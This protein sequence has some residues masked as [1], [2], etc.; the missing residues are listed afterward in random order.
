MTSSIIAVNTVP[1]NSQ[2]LPQKL[3]SP[4]PVTQFLPTDTTLIGIVN[5]KTEKWQSLTKFELFA[6]IFN[7]VEKQL[8]TQMGLNYQTDIKPWLGEQVAFT[9]LPQKDIKPGSLEG[10]FLLL[11]TV[12]DEQSL[13]VLIDRLKSSNAQEVTE[14]QYKGVKILEWKPSAPIAPVS[15]LPKSSVAAVPGI[16][17]LPMPNRN[18]IKNRGMAI[19][20]LPGYIVTASTAKPIE[21]L[22]DKP[23]GSANLAQNPNFKQLT[24]HPQ[25][26]QALFT[27]YED[28]TKVLSLFKSLAQ[29]PSLPFPIAPSAITSAQVEQY[30]SIDGLVWEQPEGLRLQLFAHRKTPSLANILTPNTAQL[31]PRIPAPAYSATT[32]SNIYLQWQMLETALNGYPQFKDGLAKLNQT[33]TSTTGLDLN[34]DILGWMDGEYALFSYPTEQGLISSQLKMGLGFFVQTTN[35]S[36]AESTLNKLGQSLKTLSGGALSTNTYNDIDGFNVNSWNFGEQSIFAYSWVDDK[37]LLI[38]TGL[39]AV[40][41]LLPQPQKQLEKDYN[42]ATA[43]SSLPFPNQGYFYIN[44]GS[45]LAWVYSLAPETFNTPSFQVFKQVI[46]SV[47]SFSTTTTTTSKKEQYDGLVVLAPAKK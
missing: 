14:R 25:Y 32:G 30:S 21:Q 11:A 18:S 38:S 19:A 24:Q 3:S 17:N 39:G 22:L 33:I 1:I 27:L 9:L 42:F 23:P 47:R 4:A 35:R 8:P 36:K 26:N 45:S 29:D 15:T 10:S 2:S 40:T 28:P 20:L 5:T 44:M 43:I 31:L 34:K 6:Q 7:A 37:T 13:Q 12:K 41:E 46:G 16:P